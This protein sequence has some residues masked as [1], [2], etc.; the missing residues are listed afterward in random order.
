VHADTPGIGENLAAFAPPGTRSARAPIDAW[1][2]EKADYDYAGN[3][4]APGKTCGHYTQMVWRT[5]LRVGCAVQAC[6]Q[7]SPFGGSTPN[8]EL[9]VCDY[10]P[11]GNIFGSKPY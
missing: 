10:A 7:N 4:C 11:P 8:W 9:W 3:S 2:A 6:S 5:S 1:A